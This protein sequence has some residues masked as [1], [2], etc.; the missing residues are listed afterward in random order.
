MY[1]S[2]LEIDMH[3]IHTYAL[4]TQFDIHCIDMYVSTSKFDKV[5]TIQHTYRRLCNQ[6]FKQSEK[7]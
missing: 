4:T 2:A 7:T 1:V 5:G 3:C 6:F